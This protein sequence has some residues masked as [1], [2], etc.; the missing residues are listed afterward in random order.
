MKLKTNIY[1][2]NKVE[3]NARIRVWVTFNKTCKDNVYENGSQA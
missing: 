1:Q 2:P 3:L